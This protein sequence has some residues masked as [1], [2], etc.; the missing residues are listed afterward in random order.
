MQKWFHEDKNLKESD[1]VYF[2]LT[3]SPLAANWRIGKI[4]YTMTSKD[5]KVR[6][7]GVSYNHDTEDGQKVFKIVDRPVRQVVKLMN[8][9]DTTIIEDIQKVHMDARKRIGDQKLVKDNAF[10]NNLE[11]PRVENA[12]DTNLHSA[13]YSLIKSTYF[14]YTVRNKPVRNSVYLKEEKFAFLV[15]TP[16]LPVNLDKN[17]KS[18]END[19]FLDWENLFFNVNIDD[20]DEL[21]EEKTEIVLI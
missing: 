17:V 1:I 8:I 7:V 5:G 12:F 18:K 4:E 19:A 20:D 6:T 3:D 15:Q 14:S 21:D 10:D 11:E 9:D 2:K 16:S 13:S